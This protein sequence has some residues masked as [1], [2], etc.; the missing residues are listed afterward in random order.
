MADDSFDRWSDEFALEV[1]LGAMQLVVYSPNFT[2]F[3]FPFF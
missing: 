1:E 3:N 2:N